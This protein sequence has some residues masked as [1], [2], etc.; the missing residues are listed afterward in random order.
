MTNQILP[1]R[2]EIKPSKMLQ[3]EV[4]VFA[5]IKMKKGETVIPASQFSKVT[6][7]SWKE[8]EKLDKITRSKIKAYC[9]GT[10][11]GFFAPPDLNYLPISWHLNHSCEPNVGFDSQSNFIAIR[12]IDRGE[13]LT[14]DYCYDETNSKF[15]M[16]C[17][18][19]SKKCRKV[20]HGDDWKKLSKQTDVYTYLSPNIKKIAKLI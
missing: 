8:Y 3:G 6:F 4:G 19:G 11:D 12:S 15:R 2:L 5:T 17:K 14:W 7:H 20:I 1:V 9:S 18:C 10:E 13:E 16:K